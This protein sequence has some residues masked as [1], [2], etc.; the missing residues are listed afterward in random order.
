MQTS[1]GFVVIRPFKSAISG[2]KT[3]VSTAA[4][5]LI[6]SPIASRKAVYMKNSS[7]VSVLWGFSDTTCYNELT[8]EISGG[9]GG[10]IVLNISSDVVVYI[11]TSSDSGKTVT[12]AEFA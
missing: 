7:N 10:E 4:A 9:D 8:A 2:Q 1:T 5:V 6:A 3:D 12:Y 11:K